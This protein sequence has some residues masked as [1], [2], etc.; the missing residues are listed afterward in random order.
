M[1]GSS[2]NE[3][4][5]REQVSLDQPLGPRDTEP[6]VE[7]EQVFLD[8]Y[9][10]WNGVHRHSK[11]AHPYYVIGRKGAGK[12]AF[13]IGTALADKTDVARIE[14]K[15][16]YTRVR[17]LIHEYRET[18]GE[19]VADELAYVWEVIFFHA[20]ML[21]IVRSKRAYLPA[22]A[23]AAV[24]NY[25]SGFGNPRKLRDD[26]LYAKVVSLISAA[27]KRR[28]GN[29]FRDD[30]WSISVAG[31]SFIDAV[32]RTRELL[33]QPGPKAVHVVVDN[34]EDLH[35]RLY[36]FGPVIT[37]LFR[38]VGRG[39][40]GDGEKFPFRLRFAFPAELLD[41]LTGLAAN[42][43]KDFGNRLVIRWN[44]QELMALAGNRL[45]LFLDLYF[46][47]A[48]KEFGLPAQHDFR[49]TEAA[50]LTLRSI[51]PDEVENGLGGTEKGEAYLMRHTQL[52]PRHL[53]VMLNRVVSSA[54][55]GMDRDDVPRVTPRQL[56]SGIF[57]AEREVLDEVF[58]AYG[59]SHPTIKEN[60][61]VLKNKIS[62][63]EKTSDLHSTYNKTGLHK[64]GGPEFVEFLQGGFDIGAFGMVT[65]HSERYTEGV[66]SYT[67]IEDLRPLEDADKVCVHPLFIQHLF[68]RHIVR[69][70][71][72]WGQKAVY[73]YGSDPLHAHGVQA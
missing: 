73:P 70:M 45:R 61:G 67:F 42:A 9:D 55:L 22:P 23:R 60:L 44:A 54:V 29:A 15:D 28:S 52:L 17:D 20:A 50:R 33:E 2:V 63:V 62:I 48:T 12:T 13:L 64:R 56:V 72:T 26:N 43:G 53:V 16:V 4:A 47:R 27:L 25:L 40:A 10:R 19:P 49:D 36:E 38:L 46:P 51:L 57:E 31:H 32:A 14:S 69:R 18:H 5:L 35:R 11:I 34:M 37:G 41:G 65:A 59:F 39:L 7:N 3:D 6:L 71:A 8:L 58:S 21:T 68:D 66:F 1:V 24:W 30:C